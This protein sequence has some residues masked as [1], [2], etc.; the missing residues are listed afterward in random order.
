[1]QQT[2]KLISTEKEFQDLQKLNS[3]ILTEHQNLFLSDNKWAYAILA[4]DAE[5][6]PIGYSISCLAYSTWK[7]VNLLIDEIFTEKPNDD[8]LAKLLYEATL[9]F[10][11]NC[12]MT[13]VR[14]ILQQPESH[15]FTNFYSGD[16]K[17]EG[18]NKDNNKTRMGIENVTKTEDWDILQLNYDA[19]V[20][21]SSKNLA[22]ENPKKDIF[23]KNNEHQIQIQK[24]EKDDIEGII[25]LIQGLAIYEKMEDDCWTNAEILG[26]H[27]LNENNVVLKNLKSKQPL[28]EMWTAKDQNQK[29]LGF[30]CIIPCFSTFP[31]DCIHSKNNNDKKILGKYI[32]LEDLYV[33]PEARGLG[34]GIHLIQTM[35]KWA[36]ANNCRAHRWACL[37]WNKPS[38]DFYQ[39]LGAENIVK[40]GRVAMYREDL[41]C[42]Y[43][44]DK[45]GWREIVI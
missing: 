38:L 33:V 32:Y 1:M 26:E 5:N 20:A 34:I 19:L 29:L 25:D 23:N 27:Y 7:G 11:K 45:D 43:E 37:N 44:N 30:C 16:G 21:L 41:K 10:A 35:T 8:A 4:Y 12:H 2:T 6:Q 3:K 17:S 42:I 28:F 24:A 39:Q 9:D 13:Q 22:E 15:D 31:D 18:K 40:N 36:L 14:Q